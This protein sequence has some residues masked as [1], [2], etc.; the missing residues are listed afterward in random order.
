MSLVIASQLEPEHNEALARHPLRPRVIAASEEEPWR[1][2]DEADVLVVRPS[3]VWREAGRA[4]VPAPWPGRLRWVCSASAGVDFYPAWLLEAPLVTCARGTASEEIADY[5]IGALYRQAK[6]FDGA[7]ARGPQEWRYRPLGQVLGSTVGLIGL[8]A[9]GTAV[10]R[11]ALALGARVVAVRRSGGGG[12]GSGGS[13]V[14]GVEVV[15]RV[16]DVVAQADHIVVAV[17]ATPATRHLVNADLLARARPGAH[18][19]N[20][21]RGSVV[22]QEALLAALDA[23]QL[24]FATLDVTEPEPLPAGHR[25]YT[26]PRVRLTPHL[27][28]NYTLARDKLLAKILADITRFGAGERPSDVVEPARGY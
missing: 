26:H 16:E 10:A 15:E 11:R 28:S 22:D 5:V 4:P 9:I 27:A 8:G 14:P 2:A 19:V 17:P 12:S 25:L 3:P 7:V 23:G 6:D 20:V 21:A 18:L 24:G 13:L 1:A